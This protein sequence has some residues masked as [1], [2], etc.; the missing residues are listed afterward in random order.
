MGIEKQDELV[1]VAPGVGVDESQALERLH[2]L[3]PGVDGTL[4]GEASLGSQVGR[5]LD[6]DHLLIEAPAPQGEVGVPSGRVLRERVDDVDEDRHDAGGAEGGGS[7]PL[8]E[9][10]GPALVMGST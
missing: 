2:P 4:A 7:Q 10:R 8:H 5:V 3:P 1:V 9:G 6:L